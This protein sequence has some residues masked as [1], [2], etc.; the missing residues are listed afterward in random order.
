MKNIDQVLEDYGKYSGGDLSEMTHK[1][2]PW[3]KTPRNKV[4]P[5]ELMR[6]YYS[7]LIKND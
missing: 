5:K 4:I 2:E 7:N 1:E 3:I 6:E